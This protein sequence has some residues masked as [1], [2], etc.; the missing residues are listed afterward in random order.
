MNPSRPSPPNSPGIV[1][2]FP[3]LLGVGGVQEASR[4]AAHALQKIAARLRCP[5]D[6]LGLN[7]PRGTHEYSAGDISIHLRGFSRSKL[8]FVL[9]ALACA[10]KNPRLVLAAHPNLAVPASWMKR[11]ALRMK[12]IV[13]A[14]GIDV[15]EPLSP[16]RHA[17]LL[18][19]DLVLAPSSYTAQK[20]AEVQSVPAHK[21]RKLPWP[22]NAEVLAMAAS[23][24][25]LPLPPAFPRAPVILTVGRWAASERYKGA[26]ELIRAVAQLRTR[27]PDLNLAV[28]G[29]GDDLSRLKKL[30][31]D[32]NASDAVH[33]LEG[34]SRRELGACYSHADIFALPSTGEGFGFVF[35]E[36]MAFAKPLVGAQAG[37][38]TDLVADG[39]NGLLVPPHDPPALAQALERLLRDE[40]LR[41]N[42]GRKG[43]QIIRE[44][45]RFDVFQT[46]FSR[47][48]AECGVDVTGLDSA[49]SA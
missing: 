48:L 1:G 22:L 27:F 10:R 30:V 45:Y 37:G 28:V 47:I 4:Q 9:A 11:F 6:F 17:A 5:T 40:S 3:E 15:W 46:E 44:K 24:E 12:V 29:G 34:I 25:A 18:A 32:L 13:L 33:F 16:R 19:A 8:R 38:A 39:V 41:A 14:H 35:L 21:I 2:L 36:A 31:L 23:P 26:D 49:I 42:L 7:D 43:V 20:L